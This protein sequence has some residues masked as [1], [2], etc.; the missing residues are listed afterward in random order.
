[1]LQLLKT[2]IEDKKLQ[3][4][5]MNSQ[6]AIGLNDLPDGTEFTVKGYVIFHI[7]KDMVEDG[8][9]DKELDSI[10]LLADDGTIYATRSA[11][12]I[13]FIEDME[14]N[15]FEDELKDGITLIKG[16]RQT[17]KGFKTVVVSIKI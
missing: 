17:R 15:G 16:S 12:V 13:R 3:F 1:M 6:T 11:A 7:T 8:D 5:L 4:A 9:E 10:S 2:N 14:A